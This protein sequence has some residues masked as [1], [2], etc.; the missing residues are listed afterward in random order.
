MEEEVAPVFQEYVFPAV[1]LVEAVSVAALPLQMVVLPVTV[2]LT[3]ATDTCSEEVEEQ[4]P[5]ETVTV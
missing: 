3:E 1:P 4:E 5:L 2:T